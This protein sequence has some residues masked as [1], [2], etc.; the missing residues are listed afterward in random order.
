M[1]TLVLRVEVRVGPGLAD[2]SVL[3]ERIA[4]AGYHVAEEV[5]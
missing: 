4:A 3:A 5:A 1:K 2:R